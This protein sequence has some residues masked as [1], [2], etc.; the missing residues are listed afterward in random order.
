MQHENN[1][2]IDN[3]IMQPLL[4]VTEAMHNMTKIKPKAKAKI[5]S[6]EKIERKPNECVQ[7]IN[8]GNTFCF[9]ATFSKC[10][11]SGSEEE[12]CKESS[13]NGVKCTLT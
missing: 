8:H 10:C 11:T 7:C 1:S 6:Q 9:N 12:Y 5:F 4:R 13:I 2:I 3:F